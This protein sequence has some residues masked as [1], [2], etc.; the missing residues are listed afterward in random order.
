MLSGQHLRHLLPPLE[1]QKTSR[2]EEEKKMRVENIEGCCDCE[3]FWG[4]G[5]WENP[6]AIQGLSGVMK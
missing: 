6:D 4:R 2:E 5:V 1:D 3:F